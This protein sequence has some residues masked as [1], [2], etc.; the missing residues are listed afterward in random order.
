MKV[1]TE[2]DGPCRQIVHVEIPAE[3]VQ[4]TFDTITGQ[5]V[6]EAR[7][8]GFRPGRAPRPLVERRY[9]EPIAE[10]VRDRLLS[11]YYRQAIEQEQ[12]EPVNVIDVKPDQPKPG[13]E[14]SFQVTVDLAPSFQLPDYHA[15]EIT[16]E[17][18]AVTDANVDE[19]IKN[20]MQRYAAYPEVDRPTQER[21]LI[22]FDYDGS[23]EGG[24]L[25]EIAGDCRELC[26]GRDVTMPMVRERELFPGFFE[27]LQGVGKDEERRVD[28]VFPEDHPLKA[29]AGKTITYQVRVKTVREEQLPQ[30]DQ[31]FFEKI[32]VK[33]EEELRRILRMQM[34]HAATENEQRRQHDAVIRYLLE[35][36]QIEE[37]PQSLLE[38][39]NR[40]ALQNMVQDFTRQGISKEK[41]EENRD[42][43]L[44]AVEHTAQ[45]RVK[46]NLILDRI[47]D[48]EKIG[49]S[50]EEISRHVA[51]MAARYRMTEAE[52]LKII[53]KRNAAAH[54]ADQLRRSKTT[55]HLFEKARVAPGN[56]GDADGTTEKED[57]PSS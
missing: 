54:V 9:A 11:E 44:R 51:E 7:L 37:L 5:F 49:I 4:S 38:E 10:Q 22:C 43:I 17:T 20:V 40:A 18:A 2:T 25:E 26:S 3:A 36:T 55:A 1:K 45:E 41:I 24:S 57:T 33:D 27:G 46:L 56:S 29:A 50:D 39:E 34:E 16:D 21:D 31:D 47:A 28:V 19:A 15:I 32:K 30:M 6:R 12:L 35:N 48:Q 52:V 23:I 42:D 13:Q 8:P 14:M 53:K